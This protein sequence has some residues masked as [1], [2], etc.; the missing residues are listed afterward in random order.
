[1]GTDGGQAKR[2][3]PRACQNRAR[4][5]RYCVQPQQADGVCSGMNASFP[6]L[7]QT[8]AALVCAVTLALSS[9]CVVLAVG[10]AGAAGAGAVAYIRG[11]LDA[12]LAGDVATLSAATTKALDE[13]R[14]AKINDT[15]SAVDANIRARTG[16]DRKIDIRLN[17]TADNLTR[18]RIRVDTF[19]DEELSRLLLDKIK[20]KL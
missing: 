17:R 5:P 1:M 2:E 9:G 3:D 16:Q 11:E 6:L 12:S 8:V 7:Q 14:F 15:Q 10:A 13:L 20:A 4:L 18:V 19:G